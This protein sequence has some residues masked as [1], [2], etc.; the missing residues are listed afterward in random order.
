MRTM[1]IEPKFPRVIYSLWLQGSDQAPA[2]VRSNW[3][4]WQTLNPEYE[5]VIL[6]KD[7]A[8]RLTGELPADISKIPPQ[9]A[10]NLIRIALLR[11]YGGIWVDA[12]ALPV[13]PLADWLEPLVARSGFIAFAY[14]GQTRP[15][16]NWFLAAEQGSL[17][18]SD[19]QR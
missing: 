6:D 14:D 15:L 4:R 10:S 16:A 3:H 5:V 11:Q 13:R 8:L 2:L 1:Q 7:T 18:V 19:G 9:A 12:T 17:L